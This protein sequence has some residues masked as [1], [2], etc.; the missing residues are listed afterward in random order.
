M[1]LKFK[2]LCPG[3]NIERVRFKRMALLPRQKVKLKIS[4]LKK[5]EMR[6]EVG[7]EKKKK[8]NVSIRVCALLSVPSG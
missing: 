1:I 4:E 7:R 6:G 8:L 5:R 3:G 2:I